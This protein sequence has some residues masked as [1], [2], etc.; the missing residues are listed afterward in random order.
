MMMKIVMMLYFS[1]L[2]CAATKEVNEMAE[3]GPQTAF[4]LH[5]YYGGRNR[6]QKVL[7]QVPKEV[8]LS[9][10]EPLNTPK[11]DKLPISNTLT[12]D[13]DE[14]SLYNLSKFV[15]KLVEAL[16][17]FF[18]SMTYI[19]LNTES[20]CTG[21]DITRGE[22]VNEFAQIHILYSIVRLQIMVLVGI[23]YQR[24][25]RQWFLNGFFAASPIM[26]C[27]NRPVLAF[28]F[29]SILVMES[30]IY[31]TI[32]YPFNLIEPPKSGHNYTGLT[33]FLIN[34]ILWI[35]RCILAPDPPM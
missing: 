20:P 13:S 10:N 12:R 7:D 8:S 22:W 9:L 23:I 34:I 15:L 26:R 3:V 27:E 33:L 6:N 30:I 24:R 32:L 5:N 25:Y 19:L 17:C 11:K 29:W 28:F 1:I 21:W 2:I 14:P 16:Y 4:D 18:N 31:V 35:L